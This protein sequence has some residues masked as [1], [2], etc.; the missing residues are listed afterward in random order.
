[1]CFSPV[2]EEFRKRIRTFPGMVNCTTIDWFLPWPEE[3]L[4]STALTTIKEITSITDKDR[5]GIV[6]LCVD[7][8][9]R[10]KTMTNR[11]F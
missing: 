1:L 11:Y 8:Q 10:L 7:M 2:G 4:R 6:E 5:P 9:V 3:A